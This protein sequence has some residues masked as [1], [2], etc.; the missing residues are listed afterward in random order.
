MGE[1][2]SAKGAGTLFKACGW[3]GKPEVAHEPKDPKPEIGFHPGSAVHS[4]SRRS[5]QGHRTA[6]A[7]S[8]V[9]PL[10]PGR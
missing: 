4:S 9:A 10:S 1:Y 7:A 6:G 3:P 8:M 2:N 5:L